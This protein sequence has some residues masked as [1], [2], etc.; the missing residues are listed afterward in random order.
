MFNIIDSFVFIE[1]CIQSHDVVFSL[2]KSLVDCMLFS[3]LAFLRSLKKGKNAEKK[4]E[5]NR[6]VERKDSAKK[7]LTHR[8]K[9][10]KEN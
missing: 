8:T 4:S 9:M 5:Q 1:Y 6:S 10:L 7:W 2:K 3:I